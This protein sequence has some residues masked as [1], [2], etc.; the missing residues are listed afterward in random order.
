MLAAQKLSKGFEI[1]SQNVVSQSLLA[2][3]PSTQLI[4]TRHCDNARSLL[5]FPGNHKL[6]FSLAFF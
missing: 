2:N 4:L 1:K 3:D 5:F 6:L